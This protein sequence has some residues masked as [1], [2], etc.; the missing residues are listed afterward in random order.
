MPV[1]DL[2]LAGSDRDY[3]LHQRQAQQDEKSSHSSTASLSYISLILV[4]VAASVCWVN[5]RIFLPLLISR[6]KILRE[7]LVGGSGGGGGRARFR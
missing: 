6:I 1:E 3:P 2:S 5:R 4:A 7:R